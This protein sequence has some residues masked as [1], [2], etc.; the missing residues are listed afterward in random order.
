MKKIWMKLHHGNLQENNYDIVDRSIPE[1]MWDNKKAVI[2]NSAYSIKGNSEVAVEVR[3]RLFAIE[4]AV[5][6]I[7]KTLF[8]KYKVEPSIQMIISELKD[9]F[10]VSQKAIGDQGFFDFWDRFVSNKRE[11]EDAKPRTIQKYDTTKVHLLKFQEQKRYPLALDNINKDFYKEYVKYLRK[12]W[13]KENGE[14]G[15]VDNS[16]GKDITSIKTFMGW[17]VGEGLTQNLIWKGFEVFEEAADIIALSRKEVHDLVMVDLSDRPALERYKDVAIVGICVGLRIKD[18]ISIDP[19]DVFIDEE[20]FSRSYIKRRTQK[21]GKTVCVPIPA[22]VSQ[23]FLKHQYKL[24]VVSE[25]KFNEH[26]K[27]ILR[28]AG[29]TKPEERTRTKGKE[30]V[31]IVKDRCDHFSA[32]RMRSTFATLMLKN[33]SPE[34]VM[35]LGGWSDYKSFQRYIKFASEDKFEA[36]DNTFGNIGTV[37]FYLNS[38]LKEDNPLLRAI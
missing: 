38:K 6:D 11:Y 1:S 34:L 27:T 20:D 28:M 31:R 25:Q 21:T 35:D 4:S 15:L 2:P 16:I 3:D 23:I 12:E 18:L 14:F 9:K 32:H 13:K 36:I 19:V 22:F 7:R 30:V 17:A 8:D 10:H 26:I 5:R 37:N 33:N 29:N 24:P